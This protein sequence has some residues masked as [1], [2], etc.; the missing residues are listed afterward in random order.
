MEEEIKNRLRAEID[1][2][3]DDMVLALV[4]DNDLIIRKNKRNEVKVHYFKPHSV[5]GYKER[6]SGK[7]DKV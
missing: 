4:N 6:L 5:L 7:T 3:I 1:I 2:S